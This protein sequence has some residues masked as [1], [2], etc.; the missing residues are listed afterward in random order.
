M[1][2]I[3]LLRKDLDS[4]VARL[5]TRKNPQAFLNVEAFKALESERKS[6]Q[7][8]TEELQSKRNQ[9]SKQIG[10]L[11]GKGEKDAAEAAKAEVAAMKSEL[12]Q[13]AARLDQIQSE[14]QAMLA[15]VP[16][17]PHDSVPVGADEEG[18]VEVRRWSPDGK[19][20]KQFDFA[21]KDHV[22]L[23]APLGLDFEAGVKLSGARF[24]VMQG[25][26][27]RLHRA[28]AQFMLDLQTEQHGYTECY[29]PYIVNS[30]S[31]KGTGQLPKFECDLFAA[32]K[33]GQDAEPVPDTAA[34]YLI[35][36]AEVPLTNLVRDEVLA[37]ERLPIK[38]TAHSPCFRSE[39][40][41]SGRDTRGLIR[42]HQFDKVEMVQIVHPEKSYEALE[43][44]TAHAEAVLQK[45]GLS[46][47]VMSLCTGDMGFGAAKTY[48]LEVWVP[49]QNTFREISSVSNCEAFQARR[50][51]A[52]FKNAQGK[53]ELVHTLNGSGLA[54]G[55]A[56]VAVLENYQNADGS[57]TVPEALVSYMGGK[58]LLKA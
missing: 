25:Q 12:E 30:D 10:M 36:T 24:T 50:M 5:L 37:E 38:L 41:S 34:L 45:L 52:R 39:A 6:I 7:T 49:A 2:D 11:M 19:G 28:L 18:N 58:T 15:A 17:L 57:I 32:K 33:G 55:R 42:Q 46:Y 14:L 44:M 27:A 53:N 29:V 22:D 1:L 43:E 56:L 3:Q 4:V 40:G 51:Q 9:L 13:S 54:V 20:P 48:D 31:L 23:G 35:P 26:I 47:R 16:N 21:L 8:R